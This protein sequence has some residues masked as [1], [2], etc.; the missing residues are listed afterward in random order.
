MNATISS[1]FSSATK[2]PLDVDWYVKLGAHARHSV[3]ASNPS[4]P[5]QSCE[6]TATGM[7]SCFPASRSAVSM[8]RS[9]PAVARKCSDDRVGGLDRAFDVVSTHFGCE[10]LPSGVPRVQERAVKLWG[11]CRDHL[12]RQTGW[13]GHEIQVPSNLGVDPCKTAQASRVG[14]TSRIPRK[15]IS[16]G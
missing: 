9:M 13:L 11:D 10:R 15:V 2:C 5:P 7:V 1:G 8:S 6:M 4:C 14:K 16:S 12:L 3:A